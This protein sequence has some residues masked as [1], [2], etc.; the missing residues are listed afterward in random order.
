MEEVNFINISYANTNKIIICIS[1]IFSKKNYFQNLY[2]K[3][4]AKK[5]YINFSK[6][7]TITKAEMML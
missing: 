2:N 6:V 4:M 7:V 5:Y 1:I 3:L